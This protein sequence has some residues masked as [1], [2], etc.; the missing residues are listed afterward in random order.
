LAAILETRNL[1]KTYHRGAVPVPVLN[2]VSLEVDEGEF[3]SI[4]GRSGSGKSTLLNL[5]GGLDTPTDGSILVKGTDISRI[6]RKGLALHRRRTVGMVFQSFNLIPSRTALENVTLALAFGEHPLRD[7]RRRAAELLSSVGLEHRFDHRPGELSGGEAQRVA[8]ARALANGPEILLA[9]EPTGNLD[10]GTS[11]EIV[12][13]LR[14]LNR[15]QGL[16]VVMVTHEEPMA[17][18]VSR[19]MLR[20]LDGRVVS[21]ECVDGAAADGAADAGVAAADGVA[22]DAGAAGGDA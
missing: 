13:L 15:E 14:G 22:D 12:A 21:E 17:R 18:E 7:R 11:E 20:L 2:G 3:L 8:V 9:D 5:V 19:R 1:H 4:V 10:S 16:T 6:G